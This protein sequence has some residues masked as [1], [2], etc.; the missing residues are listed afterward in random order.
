LA[1]NQHTNQI[2]H[3][4]DQTLVDAQ[5]QGVRSQDK[6]V[7]AVRDAANA[8]EQKQIDR[9]I[10]SYEIVHPPP[11][12]QIKADLSI[13]ITRPQDE[14]HREKITVELLQLKSQ[15]EHC[16]RCLA[17]HR[18]RCGVLSGEGAYNSRLLIITEEPDQAQTQAGTWWAGQQGT[19]LANILKAIGL[20]PEQIYIT[21]IISCAQPEDHT[22]TWPHSDKIAS[23][24]SYWQKELELLQPE[25]LISLG[26]VATQILLNKTQRLPHLRGRWHPFHN[27]ELFPTF[28]PNY[29]LKHRAYKKQAW[30]DW[31][32][33]RE[34]LIEIDHDKNN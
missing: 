23:C 28:S 9:E 16:T 30:E 12:L 1:T 17:E 21:A 15:R 18:E 4:T 14:H 10:P 5:N 31:Q 19:L 2:R 27:M 8:S 29:L 26:T 3:N 33:I 13:S 32:K 22:V 34:R 20:R 25:F 11:E 24:R 7:Q 6:T